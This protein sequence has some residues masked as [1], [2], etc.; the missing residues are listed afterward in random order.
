MDALPVMAWEARPD[1]LLDYFNREVYAYSG[2]TAQDLLGAGW[3]DIVHVDDRPRVVE[4]WSRSLATGERYEIEFRIRAL[5]NSYRWFLVQASLNRDHTPR[6]PHR[7]AGTCTDIERYVTYDAGIDELIR[8]SIIH[9]LNQPLTSML[10]NAQALQAMLRV[11]SFRGVEVME[12]L[13]DIVQED[14]RA[15]EIVGRLRDLLK[16]VG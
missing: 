12:I 3:L 7:W 8:E 1:G 5:N 15:G 11:G 14:K 4:R 10:S 9:E 6:T 13:A 2:A 16:K